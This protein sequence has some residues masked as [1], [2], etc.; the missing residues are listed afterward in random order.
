MYLRG[1]HG[2]LTDAGIRL[3]SVPD[4]VT[5]IQVTFRGNLHYLTARDSG[6]GH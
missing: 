6:P 1:T 2:G 4:D 3:V 5:L